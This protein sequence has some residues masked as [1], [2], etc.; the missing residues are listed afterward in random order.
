[1]FAVVKDTADLAFHVDVPGYLGYLRPFDQRIS[2]VPE[3]HAGAVVEIGQ[4]RNDPLV[5]GKCSDPVVH[6]ILPCRSEAVNI[7]F[8]FLDPARE[9]QVGNG[10]QLSVR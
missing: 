10:Q 3:C 5:I 9:V 1:M 6:L 8:A 2:V 7:D 4:I